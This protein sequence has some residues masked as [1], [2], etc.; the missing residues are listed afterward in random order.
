MYMLD[1]Y[2]DDLIFQNKYAAATRLSGLLDGE[3]AHDQDLLEQA[4]II[5]PLISFFDI[6]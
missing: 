6:K 5:E 1:L 4:D 3:F 2:T